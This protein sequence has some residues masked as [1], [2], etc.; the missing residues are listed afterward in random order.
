MTINE[1]TPSHGRGSRSSG[2]A[3]KSPRSN[4]GSRTLADRFAAGEPYALAFG[5][6]GAPWLSSLEELARDS[7]LEPELTDLVNEAAVTLAPVADELLVVRS[8]GFDPIGWMLEQDL[9]DDDTVGSYGPSEAALTSAAVSLPGVFLTQV[10]ALR[11][12]KLQGLDPAQTPPVKVV[13]H[14]QGLIAA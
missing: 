6:Q 5:G 9:A 12:L 13:G 7:A 4:G 11:A 8:V 2:N 10:A 1:S 3:D 14:S